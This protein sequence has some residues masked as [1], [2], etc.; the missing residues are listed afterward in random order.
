MQEITIEKMVFGGLGLAR[1]PSGVLFV[2]NALPGEVMK[3]EP[4]SK[5]HDC[6]VV[7]PVE[8]LKE[9][10]Y[11]RIP[12]CQYAG[13][14]GGCDWLHIDYSGQVL[15]KKD[16][17][18]DCLQRIGKL[19]ELP[20]PEI[21]QSPEHNYRLRAQFQIDEKGHCGFFKRKSNDVV[22]IKKCPL[23]AEP[24]NLLLEK[25][26]GIPLSQ[27][28]HYLK[29]IASENAVA[30]SPV[31]SQLTKKTVLQRVGHST[32]EVSGEC[33]FQSNRF[34]LQTL[35]EWVTPYINGGY[36]ADLYGG[37]GFFSVMLADRFSKGILVESLRPQVEMATRNFELNNITNFKAV[38]ADTEEIGTV[39]GD[40]PDLLILDP[41]RPGLTPKACDA[42]MQIQAKKILYI[43]CNP[44]TQARDVGLFVKNGGYKVEKM[45]FFDLY[46][47]THHIETGML[48]SL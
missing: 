5:K 10:P 14:C 17:I 7:R 31:L 2:E 43:S 1:T 32:F 15:F 33:F 36:C 48:L 8:F 28:I 45:A 21:F 18:I 9:S 25:L 24:L 11:R 4:G 35:A 26:S 39:I 40:T 6:T 23:L 38:H 22:P 46:P 42:V 44:S 47:N 30:S 27:D 29:V 16:I 37:T 3:V 19:K 13:V 20:E 34:L 12:S 41:P